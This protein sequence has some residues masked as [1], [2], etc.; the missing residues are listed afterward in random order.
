MSYDTDDQG[1]WEFAPGESEYDE[2]EHS[3]ETALVPVDEDERALMRPEDF[4]EEEFFYLEGQSSLVGPKDLDAVVP[5]EEKPYLEE[6]ERYWLNKPYNFAVVYH[7]KKENEKRYFVVEPLLSENEQN[8]REFLDQQAR[9]EIDWDSISTEASR[10]ERI[11]ALQETLNQLLRRYGMISRA[12]LLD[13]GA[14]YSRKAIQRVAKFLEV[15][16]DNR[17]REIDETNDEEIRSA[18]APRDED[19]D[20]TTLS[21]HQVDKLTYYIIR[22]RVG[23]GPIDPLKHDINVEDISADGPN[24][25]L[26]VDHVEYEKIIT[27]I[28]FSESQIDRFVKRLANSAGYGISRREPQV[29]AVLQDGSRAQLTFSDEATA[30]G[31]NFTI[32]QFMD[33]PFTPIDLINWETYSLDQMAYLWLTVEQGRSVIFAGGTASGKT[34]TQNAVSLFIPASRSKIVSIE[35]TPELEL[36]QKNWVQSITRSSVSKNGMDAIEEYDLLETALRQ[37]PTYII[38]GE[39]RGEEGRT[40]FQAMSSGHHTMTTFH[41]NN[42]KQVI[43]RFSTDPINVKKPYFNELDLICLQSE[44]RVDGNKVRRSTEISEVGEY[45]DRAEDGERRDKVEQHTAYQWDA[46]EDEFLDWGE[47]GNSEEDTQLSYLLDDIRRSN[48]WTEEQLNEE[49]QKR[50][51]VLAYLVTR[52]I[53]DYGG[54]AGTVQAF[55][56]EPGNILSLIANDELEDYFSNF[57]TMKSVNIDVEPE[58]EELIPRPDP[59]KDVIERAE[60][61]LNES[62]DLLRQYEGNDVDHAFG[63]V[64]EEDDRA[65]SAKETE[66][67]NPKI[68]DDCDDDQ[69]GTD[70]GRSEV[71]VDEPNPEVES[72]DVDSE[73]EESAEEADNQSEVVQEEDVSGEDHCAEF[74]DRKERYCQVPPQ[75]GRDYCYQHPTESE[76]LDDQERVDDGCDE[77]GSDAVSPSVDDDERA[78]WNSEE[79]D[80]LFAGDDD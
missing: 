30:E 35:D 33:V 48:G 1:Y 41:A 45:V 44:V 11:Q 34:T 39:V 38:M 58:I 18:P 61:V 59:N 49:L 26:F 72:A 32:R 64:D 31:S 65:D 67:Q 53:N 8:L 73:E 17:R 69:T 3:E 42:P 27:N 14:S 28:S 4:D 56:A 16:A 54:V 62:A 55:L 13:E 76:P 51:A 46:A 20:P 15:R 43:Q 70:R 47:T 21:G 22:D 79:L 12:D 68:K 60:A 66:H 77:G 74:L 63:G 52:S 37:R 7:S 36:P 2:T 29:D 10:D 71:S 23:F 57:L 5:D 78:D 80:E 40:L 24:V 9:Q 50:K 25:E 6:V 75:E 19:G